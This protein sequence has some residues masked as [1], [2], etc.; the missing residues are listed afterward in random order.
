MASFPL[1]LVDEVVNPEGEGH[2]G[3][4]RGGLGG[5][6]DIQPP[7]QP[8]AEVE[9]QAGGVLG[10]LPPVLAGEALVKDPGQVLRGDADAVVPEGE[11][12]RPRPPGGGEGE[13][14]GAL[15]VAVLHPVGDQLAQDEAQPLLVGK[16]GVLGLLHFQADLVLEEEVLVLGDGP[17]DG[18]EEGAC[19]V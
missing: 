15:G 3:P 17:V 9:A 11:G 5:Q 12:D 16:D 19:S 2:G 6:A 1:D 8:L 4:L 14:Q 18:G 13:H 7:A 10:G